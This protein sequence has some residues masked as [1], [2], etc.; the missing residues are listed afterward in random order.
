M[1][2]V[3]ALKQTC[4]IT[5][6]TLK[7]AKKLWVSQSTGKSSKSLQLHV[8]VPRANEAK[9]DAVEIF[10]LFLPRTMAGMQNL[11]TV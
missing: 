7:V 10:L 4:G 9:F 1:C 5:N 2:D 3:I 6:V 11:Y 8:P